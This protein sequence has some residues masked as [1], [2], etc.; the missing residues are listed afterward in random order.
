MVALPRLGGF[1]AAAGASARD[2]F[3]PL[4]DQQ[5]R[6]LWCSTF[7]WNFARWMEMTVTGWV[8]L[9]LTGSPWLVALVGVAR[10]AFLP[11]AGPITGALSDR[12][13]RARLMKA[14]QW[15]NCIVIGAV[16][17]ALL[18]GRGAYWQVIAASLWLGCSWGIDWPSRRA[19]LADMVGPER[20]LQAVVLDHVTQNISRIIGP[21]LGGLLLALWGGPGGYTAL[22]LSFLVASLVLQPVRPSAARVRV[23]GQSV[24]RELSAGLAHV[25]A[26]VAVW[27]VLVITIVMNM[28]L[29]PYQQL[30]SVFAEDVLAVGPVGLGLMGALN[31]V[32]ASLGLVLLPSMRRPALQ[33]LA[34]AGGSLLA[35]ATL[36]LFARSTWFEGSLALLTLIGLGTSAF[37]TMQS[38]IILSRTP[39]EMR[40]RAM[41]LLAFAIGTAPVGALETS[42][43]VERLGAPF[44]VAFNAVV[45]GALV[46]WSGWTSGLLRAGGK[47]SP[48]L[49]A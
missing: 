5:F 28:L 22:A 35:C 31:G 33:G 29:F 24:W 4:A 11:V 26:D 27:A 39:P 18:A 44:T 6:W 19:L 9:Q 47:P 21:L 42:I 43:L 45:C 36:F 49:R 12:F 20:V 2:I 40:G 17:L 23:A 8:A 30:L 10:S 3:Q 7:A 25:R 48:A 16:A 1:S 34:F 41:G 15:G 38:T 13:D 46:A 37:G 32:G 14:A